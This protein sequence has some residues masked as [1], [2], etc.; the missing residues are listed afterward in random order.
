MRIRAYP[1]Q[2]LAHAASLFQCP[3]RHFFAFAMRV[4]SIALSFRSMPLP[5]LATLLPS[6]ACLFHA[7]AFQAF[8]NR[9]PT[10]PH[11]PLPPHIERLH[12]SPVLLI[13]LLRLSCA[14]L[15]PATPL[16]SN[17]SLFRG[18][19]IP[20]YATA[21]PSKAVPRRRKSNLI[22]SNLCIAF[23]TPCHRCV[24]IAYHDFSMP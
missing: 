13:A 16:L 22:T 24:A 19:S 7:T 18:E 21:A 20:F 6:H 10:K 11:F 15:L 9:N 5:F 17:S 12:A 2:R 14:I 8:R 3:S 4:S 23:A 1:C